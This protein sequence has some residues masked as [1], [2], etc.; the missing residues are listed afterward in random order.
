MWNRGAFLSILAT[1]MASTRWMIRATA[2]A[3]ENECLLWR[4][5]HGS[6]STPR[7]VREPV[8]YGQENGPL[9]GGRRRPTPVEH[10]Q[11]A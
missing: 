3:L 9:G 10:V 2:P 11:P 4:G 6:T 1:G 8:H 7:A 5:L